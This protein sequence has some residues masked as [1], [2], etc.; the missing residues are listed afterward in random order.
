[1]SLEGDVTIGRKVK[2]SH[3]YIIEQL[4]NRSDSRLSKIGN[5]LERLKVAR[6]DADYEKSRDVT[7]EKAKSIWKQASWLKSLLEKEIKRIN[8]TKD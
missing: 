7:I 8:L 6:I 4:K 1:M 2:D 3:K 5:N